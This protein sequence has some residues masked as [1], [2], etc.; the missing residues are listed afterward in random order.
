M[1]AGNQLVLV[2][3]LGHIVVGADAETLDLVLDAGEAGEDQN[4]CLDLGN[5]KLLEHVV[6][7][8][9]GQV[10]VEKNNVVIVKFTEIDAFFPEIR[11]IDVKTL[12]FQHQLDRLRDGAV[13]FYQQYAHASPLSSPLRAS[14]RPHLRH[15]KRL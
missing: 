10:E 3:G 8:H 14:G 2:E 15:S 1:N 5:P 7:G 4:G 13:I 6:A 11:R 12:G 9:V